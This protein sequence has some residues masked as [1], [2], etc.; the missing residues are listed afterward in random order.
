MRK[1]FVLLTATILIG[2]VANST[3][4][5]TQQ[6]TGN[7]VD[8]SQ[9]TY[10]ELCELTED[11]SFKQ[12]TFED[13]QNI[14]N[15]IAEKQRQQ[16]EEE[17]K[18]EEEKKRQRESEYLKFVENNPY[19]IKKERRD[20]Q[21][22][23]TPY[24][25][26]KSNLM[27]YTDKNDN[28]VMSAKWTGVSAFF[29]GYALVSINGSTNIINEQFETI[30][31]MADGEHH[32]LAR[33]VKNNSGLYGFNFSHY[34]GELWYHGEEP[35]YYEVFGL[36]GSIKRTSYPQFTYSINEETNLITY[37]SIGTFRDGSAN[38]YRYTNPYLITNI[39]GITYNYTPEAVGSITVNG[40][41]STAINSKSK[42]VEKDTYETKYG[43]KQFSNDS[44]NIAGWKQDKNGWW[45]QNSD[46]TYPINEWKEIE[47]KQYY[48][49]SDGYMLSN[50]KTP[51]GYKV[52]VDG[53]CI[54]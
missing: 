15:A 37:Y 8:Y 18:K 2:L 52:G 5:A 27:G 49:G 25:D 50:T 33:F 46:G 20:S 40:V 32:L 44:S 12:R 38:L 14:M 31:T 10:A 24:I 3:S 17:Q 23:L 6:N 35:Y 16:W 1:K 13:I 9:L 41:F 45:Y 4:Y 48:F 19:D 30:A 36:D 29:S 28:I 39:A 42:F 43:E 26:R 22:G 7:E 47:G 51:D 21:S 34:D 54:Q 53:A 11:D